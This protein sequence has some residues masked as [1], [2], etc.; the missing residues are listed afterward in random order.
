MENRQ[1]LEHLQVW[2]GHTSN[3]IHS[4]KKTS[5]NTWSAVSVESSY[6]QRWIVHLHKWLSLHQAIYIQ[7]LCATEKFQYNLF[8]QL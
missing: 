8:P 3:Y 1:C 4:D 2:D 5:I 7:F 6:G